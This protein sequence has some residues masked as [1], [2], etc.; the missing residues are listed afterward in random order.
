[1]N[2][3]TTLPSPVGELRLVTDG[4]HLTAVL[5]V[6]SK[7]KPSE[8]NAGQE[9]AARSIAHRDAAGERKQAPARNDRLA[10]LAQARDQLSRYFAGERIEFSMPLAPAGTPFQ[11][12]VWTALLRVAYGETS[13]YGALAKQI[14]RPKASRAVGAA[15]GA[16]PLAIIVPCHRIIGAYGSLTGYAG[17]LERKTRLLAIE[18]AHGANAQLSL[19]A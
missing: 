6:S 15:V 4:S 2:Y 7:K 11:R 12:A 18:G 10:I 17:G 9:I 14:G 5:F 19:A 16:N 1:M 8:K 3:Y 13:T